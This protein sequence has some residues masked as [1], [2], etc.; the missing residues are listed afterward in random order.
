MLN[1]LLESRAPRTRQIGSTIAS[2]ILHAGLIASAVALTLPG[3]VDANAI[4]V[5]PARSLVFI[6]PV[7]TPLPNRSPAHMSPRSGAIALP[8]VALPTIVPMTLPSI[9]IGP[10]LAPDEV[11]IGAGLRGP[12]PFDDGEP[13][14]F[15]GATGAA[16]DERLVDRTP[17]LVGRSREP[18]Y[19]AALRN[20]GVQGRVVVQFVVDTLGRAELGTLQVLDGGHPLFVE[21][22]R[23]ALA[24]YRFSVGEAGGRAVRTRVQI[25]F[26]F[27]LVR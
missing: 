8:Q 27:T 13:S 18:R 9:D 26:D 10:V 3:P 21:S 20:A 11:R 24:S 16:V 12:S 14:S 6:D 17:R 25:P 1:V 4:P 22:I 5:A 7:Q 2:A 15:G 23:A 19:P